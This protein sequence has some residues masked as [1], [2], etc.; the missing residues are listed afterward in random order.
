MKTKDSEETIITEDS[1]K[2]TDNN[3]NNQTN[4]KDNAVNSSDNKKKNVKESLKSGVVGA[5]TGIFTGGLAAMLMGMAPAE[6]IP[7]PE[8]DGNN[9]G[10]STPALNVVDDGLPI[11]NDI[12]ED[13]S[14]NE[15][16]AAAREEVGPGGIFEWHGQIH[17]TYSIDEWNAL[18]SEEQREFNSH[19]AWNQTGASEH[20]SQVSSSG[21]NVGDVEVVAQNDIIDYANEDIDIVSVEHND[22]N[23]D[24]T[25]NAEANHTEVVDVSQV[26]EVDV[27]LADDIEVLGVVHNSDLNANVGIISVDGHDV[28]L[29]DVD[30]D[31]TFDAMGADLNGNGHV[32][33]GEIVDIRTQNL[34]VEDLGGFSDIATSDMYASNDGPDYMNDEMSDAIDGGMMV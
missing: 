4:V 15:A 1:S 29:I 11:A 27:S 19:F 22:N 17:T 28:V 3:S 5:G 9:H 12:S 6:D 32:D 13:M 2:L 33:D 24:Y 20:I 14:F 7:H 23:T 16:F 30:N 34:T 8:P 10:N 31:L 18:S 25:N 21:E 26:D